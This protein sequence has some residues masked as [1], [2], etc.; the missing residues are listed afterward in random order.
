MNAPLHVFTQVPTIDAP[1]S[2]R[3]SR[4]TQDA[5]KV[6]EQAPKP[7]FE[8]S[9]DAFGDGA[10]VVEEKPSATS[11]L[12]KQFQ[13]RLKQ[14]EDVSSSLRKLVLAQQ[15]E[16]ASVTASSMSTTRLVGF[17]A[18]SGTAGFLIAVLSFLILCM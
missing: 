17:G 16:L 11:P 5:V 6:V 8:T 9:S 10:K 18:L 15:Q 12:A 14:E 7:V 1:H 4:D 2:N 3:K 13:R